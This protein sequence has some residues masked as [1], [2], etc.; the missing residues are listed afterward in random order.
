MPK[1][2]EPL[3]LTRTGIDQIFEAQIYQRSLRD[4]F[5]EQSNPRFD[6]SKRIFGICLSGG[7]PRSFS[8]SLGQL[9]GIISNN[10]LQ[11]VGAISC[12]SGGSWFGSLFSYAPTSFTD[13]QLLGPVVPP[14]QLTV[15]MVDKISN[16]NLGHPITK[17]TNGS[18]SDIL[19]DLYADYLVGELPYNRIYSR[20]LGR[21]LLKPFGLDDVTKFFTVDTFTAQRIVDHNTPGLDLS[22]FFIMRPE[23]PFFIAG[24]TQVWPEGEGEVL[25][26]FEYSARYAGTPQLFLGQGAAGRDIGFGWVDAFAFDTGTPSVPSLT[27]DGVWVQVQVPASKPRFVLSDVMGS[28]GAAP[29]SAL[30]YFKRP[31]WFPEF[32]YWPLVNVGQES[33]FTYSFVDGGDYENIGIVPLLRRRFP[34]IIAFVNTSI[35]LGSNSTSAVDGVSGDVARLFGF[36]PADPL[37]NSQDTQIFPKEQFKALAQGLKQAKS[38]NLPVTFVDTYEIHQPNAFG[39]PPYPKDIFDGKVEVQWAYN[40]IYGDW[41]RALKPD[42]ARLL[43]S[44]APTNFMANFPNYATVFQNKDSLGIPEVLLLTPRQVNL[45]SNMWASAFAGPLGEQLA[46]SQERFGGY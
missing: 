46:A 3:S 11:S 13:E 9:R 12:V 5:P 8:A 31:G 18:I 4:T 25:R 22:D 26:Q 43:E 23:R 2:I 40:D 15:D 1:P 34:V 41:K 16:E 42:V 35:P 36:I 6:P 17:M 32:S 37:F 38:E 30:D 10:L 45:L 20:M 29:G 44:T 14:G 7:G 19:A 27:S 28:S 33:A 24:A 39:I 21:L